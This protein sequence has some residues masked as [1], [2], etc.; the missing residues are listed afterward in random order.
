[1]IKNLIIFVLSLIM[2]YPS[3]DAALWHK[4]NDLG[5]DI[6]KEEYPDSKDV[7]PKKIEGDETLVI[8]GG[9]EMQE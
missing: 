9:V 2:I 7:E 6:I 1:M 5:N 3:C 8:Q 4:G